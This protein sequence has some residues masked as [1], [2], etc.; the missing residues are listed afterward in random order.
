VQVLQTE[1]NKPLTI[2]MKAVNDREMGWFTKLALGLAGFLI[3]YLISLRAVSGRK[4][5]AV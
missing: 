2:S 4:T 3:L 5:A 1:V